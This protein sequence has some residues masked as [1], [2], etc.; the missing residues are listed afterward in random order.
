MFQTWPTYTLHDNAV[1]DEN[2]DIWI[3]GHSVCYKILM[4]LED[5]K[6][7]SPSQVLRLKT[8]DGLITDMTEPFA[9]DGKLISGSSVALYVKNK[10]FIGSIYSQTVVCD[11]EYI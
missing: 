3:A 2:G 10:L 11:V 5:P 7:I 4:Y 6:V 9:D 8:K 1:V